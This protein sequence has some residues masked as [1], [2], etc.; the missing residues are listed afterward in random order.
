MNSC[1]AVSLKV[2]VV[3]S[4]I[5]ALAISLSAHNRRKQIFSNITMRDLLQNIEECKEYKD[6]VKK[7]SHRQCMESSSTTT[8]IFPAQ[9]LWILEIYGK[10][11]KRKFAFGV[12]SK[13]TSDA[14]APG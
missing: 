11:E 13:S 2:Y 9:L 4:G 5:W 14:S 6:V 7:D 1:L 10:K 8:N 12:V 3:R